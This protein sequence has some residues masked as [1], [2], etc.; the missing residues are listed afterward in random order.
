MSFA[1]SHPT[2]TKDISRKG[3]NPHKPWTVIQRE[4]KRMARSI[5]YFFHVIYGADTELGKSI[6]GWSLQFPLFPYCCSPYSAYKDLPYFPLFRLSDIDRLS[7]C[8]RVDTAVMES[9]KQNQLRNINSFPRSWK[10]IFF[11]QLLR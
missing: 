7:L 5:S 3:E 10:R 4:F 9:H 11:N 6:T 8:S 2:K 1:F